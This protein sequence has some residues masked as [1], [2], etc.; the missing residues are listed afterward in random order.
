MTV[1]SQT[2]SL[3]KELQTGWTELM[4]RLD[5]RDGDDDDDVFRRRRRR[6]RDDDDGDD[7][8]VHRRY[9]HGGDDGGD[10]GGGRDGRRCEEKR[11]HRYPGQRWVQQ[12]Q[13]PQEWQK[14]EQG[15][16]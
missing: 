14:Q 2:D 8:D 1:Y 5:G 13:P 11:R 12:A 16:L 10:D 15:E 6:G 7:G 3:P 4:F 9:R